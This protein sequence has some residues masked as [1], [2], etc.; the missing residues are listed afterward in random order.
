MISFELDDLFSRIQKINKMEVYPVKSDNLTEAVR[1]FADLRSIN[2]GDKVKRA[3]KP[4][5]T[6]NRKEIL[7]S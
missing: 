3:F 5:T 6:K 2:I 1:F 4:L 7:P